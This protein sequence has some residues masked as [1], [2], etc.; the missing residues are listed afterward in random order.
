[1]T[2]EANKKLII[3]TYLELLGISDHLLDL[4]L[5]QTSLVVG[6]G[7]LV[8]LSSRLVRCSHV[9]DAVRVNVERHL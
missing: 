3:T 7:D 8:L 5:R 9:E 4:V 1:M 6:D 2:T